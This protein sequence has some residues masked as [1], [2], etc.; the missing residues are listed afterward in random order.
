MDIETELQEKWLVLWWALSLSALAIGI[1][2]RR[3]FFKPFLFSRLPDIEGKDVIKGFSLFL[4]TQLLLVPM[5]AGAVFTLKGWSA[6]LSEPE[7][8]W[9]NLSM[10]L[11]GF[12]AALCAYYF[13]TVEQKK[14]LLQQN[15]S[16]WVHHVGQGVAYWFVC[17]PIVLA[18]N[19]MLSIFLWHLFR[20]PFNEQSA[21]ISMR[22]AADNPVLFGTLGLAIV[23]LVPFTEEYLFRGLLQTWLKRK[24]NRSWAAILVS[25][26]IFSIFHFTVAQG[27][28]NI[29]LLSTLF[30]LSCVLGYV[31]ERQRSL[32]APIGLHSFFNFMSLLMILVAK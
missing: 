4:V 31:F 32:W 26:F 24:F 1:A 28:T 17:F 11:G 27:F 13:L 14:Q 8:G 21:V 20:Q 10:V 5:I 19:Q 3:G 16:S 22:H 18:F 9:L 2:W 12:A 23:T 29:E 15:G 6:H 25:S 7:K 30:L